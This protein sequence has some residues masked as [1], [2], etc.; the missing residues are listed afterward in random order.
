MHYSQDGTQYHVGL[1]AG[2]VGKY[3]LLPGDPKRCLPEGPLPGDGAEPEDGHGAK[4]RHLGQ[5]RPAV[6]PGG[7]PCLLPPAERR[8]PG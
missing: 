7:H 4:T 1:K 8:G 2:D 6:H 5:L 3:V